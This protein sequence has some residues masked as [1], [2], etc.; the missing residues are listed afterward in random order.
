MAKNQEEIR[1]TVPA[2]N[3]WHSDDLE[4]KAKKHDMKKGDFV[5]KA[6]DTFINFDDNFIELIDQYA[7]QFHVAPHMVIQ[8]F[9]IEKLAKERAEDIVYG[10]QSRIRK[11][12]ITVSDGDG[13]RMMTGKELEKHLIDLYTREYQ[14][15]KNEIESRRKNRS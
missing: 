2:G 13:Y 1:A 7:D 11:E 4:V 10:Q 14:H 12:F 15:E 8:N 9:I 6:V 3:A 5:L